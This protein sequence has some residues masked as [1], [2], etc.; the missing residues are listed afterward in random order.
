MCLTVFFKTKPSYAK[1]S[2]NEA[3]HID[4]KLSVLDVVEVL[5]YTYK[6]VQPVSVVA[7][8]RTTFVPRRPTSN[9]VM[10]LRFCLV[11]LL[12]PL[13]QRILRRCDLQ[14]NPGV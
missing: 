13:L 12:V 9:R 5:V 11:F 7:R 8:S 10:Y 3:H 2:D 14:T 6:A 1:I 4:P